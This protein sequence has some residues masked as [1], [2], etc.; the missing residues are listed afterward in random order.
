[1]ALHKAHPLLDLVRPKISDR[2]MARQTLQK[3][4]HDYHARDREMQVDDP[5]YAKD[6]RHPK[7]WISGTVFEKTGPVLVQVL[8]KTI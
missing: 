3:L 6:F 8:L 7:T 1:M 4:A 5:V 2:V